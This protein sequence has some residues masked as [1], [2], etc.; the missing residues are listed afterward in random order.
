MRGRP[1]PAVGTTDAKLQQRKLD[2]LKR[3][4]HRIGDTRTLPYSVHMIG[5]GG[6]GARIVE[7]VLRDAPDDLLAADGSRLSALAI[8]IGDQDLDGI[9]SLASKFPAARAHVETAALHVPG[10]E[11]LFDTLQRHRSLAN[12]FIARHRLLCA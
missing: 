9:R 11:E 5:L 7:Q 8:D 12:L 4:I 1:T 10:S 3:G 2:A 6:A